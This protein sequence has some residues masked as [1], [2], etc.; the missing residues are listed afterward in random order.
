MAQVDE[1]RADKAW[2]AYVQSGLDKSVPPI[3]RHRCADSFI[4]R[5]PQLLEWILR[6]ST[7]PLVCASYGRAGLARMR[8]AGITRTWHSARAHACS[9]FPSSTATFLLERG[10]L[11]CTVLELRPASARHSTVAVEWAH[12]ILVRTSLVLDGRADVDVVAAERC[13]ARTAL[14]GYRGALLVVIHVLRIRASSVLRR[15]AA[16]AVPSRT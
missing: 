11:P 6:I 4:R 16:R 9:N 1:A 10:V 8:L 2:T 5:V 14:E 15:S 12:S 7:R 13:C 3:L